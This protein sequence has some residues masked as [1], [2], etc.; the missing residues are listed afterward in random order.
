MLVETFGMA[1]WCRNKGCQEVEALKTGDNLLRDER[2][3]IM[4]ALKTT[5]QM[6]EIKPGR[7]TST[8][9]SLRLREESAP[10]QVIQLQKG[11][12]SKP[13]Q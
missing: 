12:R 11:E 10:F 5:R 13:S 8:L 4:K 9:F 2:C 6:L 3:P 7:R 1:F